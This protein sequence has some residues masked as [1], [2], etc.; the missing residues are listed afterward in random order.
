[1]VHM[2]NRQTLEDAAVV[3]AAPER[4]PRVPRGI[5]MP[6]SLWDFVDNHA[7]AIGEDSAGA[8][9]ERWVREKLEAVRKV[10]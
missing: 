4:E 6:A 1:M 8:L 9:I 10:A 5:R 3:H 7:A 2:A